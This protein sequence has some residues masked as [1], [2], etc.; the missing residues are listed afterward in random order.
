MECN[1]KGYDFRAL[2]VTLYPGE[3]FYAE[4]GALIYLESGIDKSVQFDRSLGRVI[5][6]KLSGEALFLVK[7]QNMS[8]VPKKL[9]VG[10]KVGIL[11]IKVDG[12]RVMCRRGAYIAS[13]NQVKLGLK[14]SAG[15]LL[16]GAGLL[17]RIDS[18]GT[19][20]LDSYGLPVEVNLKVNESIEVDEN[21]LIALVGIE[22]SQLDA[23]WSVGNMLHGE[24]LSLLRITGPGKV[25]INPTNIFTS[26]QQ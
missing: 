1:L 19:I 11:P 6:S 2:E 26:N 21:N 20:F 5:Q 4:R 7:F 13:T 16:G 17:Q 9:L 10:G 12:V 15:A 3:C 18:C 25:Y 14:I 8:S 22:E 23:S 24:G